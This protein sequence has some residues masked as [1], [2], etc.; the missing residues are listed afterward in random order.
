M[1]QS[2]A[3]GR[4][5]MIRKNAGVND[6]LALAELQVLMNGRNVAQGQS[7]VTSGSYDRAWH[8]ASHLVDGKTATSSGIYASATT[9]DGWIQ[10]DLGAI[11]RIDEIK[12]FGRTDELASQNGN[13]TVYVSN[14][15]LANLSA[16]QIENTAGV[17]I[18]RQ[19]GQAAITSVTTPMTLHGSNGADKFVGI[20]GEQWVDG[21]GGSDTVDYSKLGNTSSLANA[22]V[23]ADLSKGKAYQYLGYFDGFELDGRDFTSDYIDTGRTNGDFWRNIYTATE[24]TAPPQGWYMGAKA[25][26]GAGNNYLLVNGSYDS[27]HA[28][29]RKAFTGLETGSDYTLH[30]AMMNGG[31]APRVQLYVNGL[32]SGSPL[33]LAWSQGWT[34]VAVSFKAA[35]ANVTLELRDLNTNGAGNDIGLDNL[36]L[37]KGN[38]AT[39][40]QEID[41]LQS[42]ENLV[43]TSTSDQLFGSDADNVLV[44]NDGADLLDGRAGNDTLDGGN[45]NDA[46]VFERGTGQDIIVDRGVSVDQLDAMRFG[47]GIAVTDIRFSRKENDLVVWLRGSTDQFTI[48]NW[49]LGEQYPIEIFVT[50]DGRALYSG[51]V[52]NLVKVMGLKI[53]PRVIEQYIDANWSLSQKSTSARTTYEDN[54]DNVETAQRLLNDWKDK[55]PNAPSFSVKMAES[56]ATLYGEYYTLGSGNYLRPDVL[57]QKATDTSLSSSVR[58]A[59]AFWGQPGFFSLIDIYPD[60]GFRL[61]PDFLSARRD[62]AAVFQHNLIPSSNADIEGLLIGAAYRNIAGQTTAG[63]ATLEQ[64]VAKAVAL[65]N[66]QAQLKAASDSNSFGHL[67][68]ALAKDDLVQVYENLNS[69]LS[70]S[71][72]ASLKVDTDSGQ[73]TT[74][75]NT[76]YATIFQGNLQSSDLKTAIADLY[77]TEISSGKRLRADLADAQKNADAHLT[78]LVPGAVKYGVA[79]QDFAQQVQIFGA[80][81][82]G[83]PVSIS[84]AFMQ[85]GLYDQYRQIYIEQ[86]ATGKLFSSLLSAGVS[87]K[88]ATDIFVTNTLGLSAVLDEGLIKQYSTQVKQNLFDLTYEAI[89]NHA[90]LQEYLKVFGDSS[91]HF[92]EAKLLAFISVLPD[93]V[94]KDADGNLISVSDIAKTMRQVF[95]GMQGGQKLA[96]ALN[97]LKFTDTSA[98]KLYISGKYHAV[99][100]IFGAVVLLVKGIE[101]GE[102]GIDPNDIAQ[103]VG[104][105]ASVIGQIGE[106]SARY[107]KANIGGDWFR[108]NA[109]GKTAGS[110]GGF[111]GGALSLVSAIDA[112]Q[113][114]DNVHGGLAVAQVALG[115]TSALSS[116]VE[117]AVNLTNYALNTLTKVV[118]VL[119]PGF[120][121]FAGVASAASLTGTVAS[122]IGGVTSIATAG[123]SLGIM[124]NDLVQ[125]IQQ[126]NREIAFEKAFYPEAAKYGVRYDSGAAHREIDDAD[127]AIPFVYTGAG[128]CTL[129][130]D[131]GVNGGMRI[132]ISDFDGDNIIRPKQGKTI[133]DRIIVRYQNDGGDGNNTI[134]LGNGDNSIT[135]GNGNNKIALGNGSNIVVLENG[136]NTI[137]VG[138][139]N[140]SI[141]VGKGINLITLGAGTN[142][143]TVDAGQALVKVTS[144][145]YWTTEHHQ[146][147]QGTN[148]AEVTVDYSSV[149]HGGVQ[150]VL[151][152]TTREDTTHWYHDT[153]IG[154]NNAI[155][156]QYRNIFY[157][158][159]KGNR[160]WGGNSGDFAYGGNGDDVFILGV[161]DDYVEGGGG[162]DVLDGGKGV[163]TLIGGR[164]N[165]S[166]VI[167]SLADVVT[168]KAGEGIDT[169]KASVSYSLAALPNIENLTLTGDAITHGRYILIMKNAGIDRALQLAE[170]QVLNEAGTNL[171]SHGTVSATTPYTSASRYAPERVIDGNTGGDWWNDGGFTSQ[172]HDQAYLQID[173]KSSQDIRNI[174]VWGYTVGGEYDLGT[175]NNGDY[176]VYVSDFNMLGFSSTQLQQMKAV[177][178][179]RQIGAGTDRDVQIDALFYNSTASIAGPGSGDPMPRSVAVTHDEWVVPGGR[180]NGTGNDAAN[181]LTGNAWG[182]ALNGGKGD[183]TL[184]GGDGNDT[185]T[186]EQGAD[187]F[188][189]NTALSTRNLDVVTDF[190]R[191][192]GDQIVL[193]SAIFKC[194]KGHTD[195]R[196]NFRLSTQAAVGGDDYIVYNS[197]TGQLIYDESGSSVNVGVVFALLANKPQDISATQFVVM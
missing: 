76:A 154:V 99:G 112:F 128:G 196:Q 170:V 8:N 161:G 47:S 14:M 24:K 25:S 70:E 40:Y 183:D 55:N 26:D 105:A 130:L 46:Y 34:D 30:F 111:I 122:M 31:F 137:E 66:L 96:D 36:V 84:L 27:K 173:L 9:K 5:I 138:N 41:S 165:D 82:A 190:S 11:T 167:D 20:A 107:F 120:N 179:F 49:Y 54:I 169:I 181:Q 65:M 38:A 188:V 35:S 123:L 94:M 103:Y 68:P 39:P 151:E 69:Q 19:N 72:S 108:L 184:M 58:E 119:S 135:L 52:E 28:F 106:G 143:V 118:N 23:I 77:S 97:K 93:D 100:S 156:G 172:S 195:L 197:S 13:F 2:V 50:Q 75:V 168:E 42:I 78:S 116:G 102:S 104:A 48:K 92:S 124:I 61:T 146:T 155:G 79:L 16:A 98:S 125:S 189:F 193:D 80:A 15:S 51:N 43:G 109:L 136:L 114:G 158:N 57:R 90:S 89:L 153:L 110:A 117:A 83:Y 192:E 191:N 10:V 1:S 149:N 164:G 32:A 187:R 113:H 129:N 131:D 64:R 180:L 67:Y 178:Y 63:D 56:L 152:G 71:L 37:V 91:G 142:Q 4:Y 73:L 3:I 115:F 45:G 85:T 186:G 162:N 44:G 88:T 177:D 60:D 62:I 150:I 134:T 21:G 166:Y 6:Y 121:G 127:S 175:K 18:S 145:E 159:D 144:S 140:N 139:G 7:V 194:L 17:Y 12:L 147:I 22:G 171:A 174:N 74:R 53:S 141:K 87:I 81:N 29:W 163:D 33:K 133:N 157:G 148:A 132:I 126:T 176:T 101:D 95:G 86:I 182:N 160:F 59:A 185:L